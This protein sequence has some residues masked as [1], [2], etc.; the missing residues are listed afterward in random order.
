MT[1][2]AIF[3]LMTLN[4]LLRYFVP[5]YRDAFIYLIFGKDYVDVFLCRYWRRIGACQ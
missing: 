1:N 3:D 2:V 5:E 4:V